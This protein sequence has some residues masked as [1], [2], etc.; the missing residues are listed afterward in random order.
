LVTL[1]TTRTSLREQ[2]EEVANDRQ[3][4]RGGRERHRVSNPGHADRDSFWAARIDVVFCRA[5]AIAPINS[6][7]TY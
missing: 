7:M 6:A 2:R 3:N 1:K 5:P 4:D